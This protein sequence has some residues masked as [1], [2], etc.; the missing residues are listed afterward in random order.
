MTIEQAARGSVIREGP[1]EVAQYDLTQR[2]IPF[3]DR[4][5]AAPLV[6]FL[7]S[8]EVGSLLRTSEF[9]Y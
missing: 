9:L 6:E 3:L 5:M 1:Q 8:T 4:H 2:I 7:I